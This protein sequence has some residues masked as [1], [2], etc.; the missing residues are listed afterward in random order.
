VGAW[1]ERPGIGRRYIIF[2]GFRA[3]DDAREIGALLLVGVVLRIPIRER[4]RRDGVLLDLARLDQPGDAIA[5]LSRA[6][7]S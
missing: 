2:A 3:I 4:M 1:H 6:H 5:R 7:S